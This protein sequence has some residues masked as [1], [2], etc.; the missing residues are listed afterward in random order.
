MT[1]AC[2][3]SGAEALPMIRTAKELVAAMQL[4]VIEPYVRR[5]RE[6]RARIMAMKEG[7]G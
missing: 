6:L 4:P 7:G 3:G 2:A 5:V 1:A